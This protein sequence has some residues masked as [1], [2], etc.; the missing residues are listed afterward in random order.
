MPRGGAR[1]GAGRPQ[2]PLD[3]WERMHIGAMCEN[4]QNQLAEEARLA[5]VNEALDDE[6]REE[7]WP[8]VRSIPVAKR[9]AWLGSDD[10]KLHFEVVESARAEVQKRA[11]Q[12]RRIKGNYALRETVLERVRIERSQALGFELSKSYVDRCW[13]EYRREL[14]DDA[15]AL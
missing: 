2:I 15:G 3:T 5:A 12:K 10:A 11:R 6:L 8:Y 13:N 14:L 7:I 9:T 4:L 1:R